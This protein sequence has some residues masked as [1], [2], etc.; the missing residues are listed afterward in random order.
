MKRKLDIWPLVLSLK[1][2]KT[3]DNKSRPLK[4][5]CVLALQSIYVALIMLIYCFML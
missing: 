1:C 3:G 2:K 5:K 4:K